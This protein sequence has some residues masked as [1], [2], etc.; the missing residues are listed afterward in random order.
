MDIS[1]YGLSCFR[2]REG[3]V[4][5]VCD[6]F[7]KSIGLTLPKLRADIVTV[8]HDRP[9][10]NA[11]ER[12]GGESKVLRGPG[13][14]EVKNTFVS[15][16]AT[17]HRKKGDLAERNIAYFFELGDLT[18]GHLGDLGEVLTQ[19]EIEALNI[20]E[21][22]VLM[23]PVGGHE[24]L[25]PAR[26]VEII[27]MLEPRLVIPMH[28]RHDGLA[29]EVADQLEPVEKFLKEFGA[30]V[31]DPVDMLKVSKNSLPEET[32]VVLLNLTL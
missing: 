5:V 18:V 9:G 17:F 8:S 20:G 29:A 6:P 21:L 28:Y 13:E 31:P 10:H 2:I 32:Q 1:W 3:G 23:V 15:G 24:A 7:D 16:L 22:D 19:S 4:T 26:A 27:G 14:Y 25:D 11:V 12:V 30:A